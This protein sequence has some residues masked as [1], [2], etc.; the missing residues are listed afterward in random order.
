MHTLCCTG[1]FWHLKEPDFSGTG[2]IMKDIKNVKQHI[3]I[4]VDPTSSLA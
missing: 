3:R 2:D 4:S 1:H